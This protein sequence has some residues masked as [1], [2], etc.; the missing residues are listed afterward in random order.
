LAQ[1]VTTQS[2]KNIKIKPQ[3]TVII[4][5]T[6]YFEQFGLMVFRSSHLKQNL[7]WYKVQH[8]TNELYR[9][10]IQELIDDGWQ[11]LAI[12]ADGKPGIK[13]LF[14]DIPFQLCQFHQFATVTRYISKNPKL[15]AGKDLRDLMFFLKKTSQQNFTSW[16]QEW[17]HIW[18]DFL[19][20]KTINPITKRSTFTHDRLR[21]AYH[22]LKRNLPNL[23]TFE[24]HK[25][26]FKIPKTTNA[27]DGYFGH[28]KSKISVHRG[29]SKATQMKLTERLIFE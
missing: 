25:N 14:P 12:V 13:R 10:G 5:D 9:K 24:Q 28:L 16:L 11:I 17:H 18:Q 4:I 3:S 26:E 15:E 8:E 7:L 19:N 6:T 21:S 27:I 23:F 1:A 29:A 22:S 2:G 20:E